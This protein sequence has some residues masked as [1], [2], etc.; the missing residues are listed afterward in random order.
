MVGARFVST[1][2]AWLEAKIEVDG[3]LLCVMDEFSFSPEAPTPGTL[4][5]VE[6][7]FIC[8]EDESWEQLFSGNPSKV[9]GIEAIDGWKY[10]ALGQIRSIDPVVV[11]CGLFRVDDVVHTSDPRVVGE[12]V[13]FTISRLGAVA[14]AT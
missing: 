9:L 14:Y 7:S 10:R 4:V 5:D 8:D 12:Y 2:G 6:F 11:D 1:N 3:K 13:G